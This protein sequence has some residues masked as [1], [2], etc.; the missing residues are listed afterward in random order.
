MV[1]VELIQTLQE[2][3]SVLDSRRP[4]KDG[5]RAYVL[6]TTQPLLEKII[7]LLDSTDG[8]QASF[9]QQVVSSVMNSV[10]DWL[11]SHE[12]NQ[13]D[14]SKAA[15]AA[16]EPCERTSIRPSDWAQM[17]EL[18]LWFGEAGKYFSGEFL[19]ESLGGSTSD[20]E[21]ALEERLDLQSRLD[22]WVSILSIGR[23]VQLRELDGDEAS[24]VC[25]ERKSKRTKMMA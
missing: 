20:W 14:G 7:A 17:V 8:F 16:D 4:C 18:C 23:A 13:D 24:S 11:A 21:A 2:L 15:I 6:S 3:S 9:H 25:V 1:I 12:P 5:S 10:F 19:Q 22:R